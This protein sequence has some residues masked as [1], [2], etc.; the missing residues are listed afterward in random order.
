MNCPLLT[1]IFPL[2]FDELK[3]KKIYFEHKCRMCKPIFYTQNIYCFL[4]EKRDD[5]YVIKLVDETTYANGRQ[6]TVKKMFW[7][8]SKNTL[9]CVKKY[10]RTNEEL[11]DVFDNT[12]NKETL[13]ANYS[14][15]SFEE[16]SIMMFREPPKII[17]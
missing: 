9:S 17:Y 2:T 12:I 7:N 11:L 3:D 13:H 15:E 6:Y 4:D 1:K 14:K 5:I 10:F 8:P 16:D